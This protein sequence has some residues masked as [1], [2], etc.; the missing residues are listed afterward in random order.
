MQ[1]S[2]PSFANNSAI[3]AKFSCQGQNI[4]PELQISGVSSEIKSLALIMDDPDAP[5]GDWVHW[6]IWN[7]PPNTKSI[8]ENVSPKFAT[9]GK[10]TRELQ[11]YGGPCPPTGIHRYF[12]R[13]YGLSTELDIQATSTKADL[14]K[15]M[16]GKIFDE[17]QLMGTYRK[18]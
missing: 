14:L 8:P 3:P 1:L 17:C 12:F 16:Q 9:Q 2:S 18:S 7:I 6:I 10:N 15:A 4:N 13:L 5:N 11:T